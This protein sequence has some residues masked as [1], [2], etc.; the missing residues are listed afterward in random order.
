MSVR[1]E[2]GSRRRRRRSRTGIMYILQKE[3]RGIKV[4]K[5]DKNEKELS[6]AF[7]RTSSA[8]AYEDGDASHYRYNQ[9]KGHRL[10]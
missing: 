3:A 4:T 9:S 7:Y 8:S 1:K 5:K 2:Y 6:F 10:A